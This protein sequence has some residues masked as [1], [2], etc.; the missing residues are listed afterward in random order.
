MVAAAGI[1]K[2]VNNSTAKTPRTPRS[3]K[4]ESETLGLSPATGYPHQCANQV[5]QGESQKECRQPQVKALPIFLLFL[6]HDEPL[7]CSIANV[8]LHV[9]TKKKRA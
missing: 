2:Q 9:V 1:T 5:Q 3:E 6:C 8:M 7:R 4:E